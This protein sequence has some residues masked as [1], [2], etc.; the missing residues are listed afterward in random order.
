LVATFHPTD[1]TLL[2]T[3]GKSHIYFWS[4]EGA[5]LSKRQGLFEVS[6]WGL[7]MHWS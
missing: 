2:I 5:S 6:A 4:L 7:G 1:P 3:C